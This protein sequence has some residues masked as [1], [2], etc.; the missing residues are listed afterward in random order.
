MS[1]GRS[2]GEGEDRDGAQAVRRKPFPER[3]GSG[4]TSTDRERGASEAGARRRYWWRAW[5]RQRITPQKPATVVGV[6]QR[7]VGVERRLRP[8]RQSR[9]VWW[10][11]LLLSLAA[12]AASIAIS[13]WPY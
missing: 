7:A 2:R 12:V 1:T 5:I 4:R 13:F 10:C 6:T 3:I 8:P 11:V 9:R